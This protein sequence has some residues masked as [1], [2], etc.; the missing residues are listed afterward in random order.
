MKKTTLILSALL[1][2]ISAWAGNDCSTQMS[3]L[4]LKDLSKYTILT[5][6]NGNTCVS[7]VAFCEGSDFVVDIIYVA[8]DANPSSNNQDGSQA[9][10]LIV[11][12]F[13]QPV[14]E[15]FTRKARFTD[16]GWF[17]SG[18]ESGLAKRNVIWFYAYGPCSNPGD[19]TRST[20]TGS[21][22]FSL[23]KLPSGGTNSGGS[24]PYIKLCGHGKDFTTGKVSIWYSISSSPD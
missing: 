22:L 11:H 19:F 1:T 10:Y 2:T 8:G 18:S 20:G 14:G 21:G 17:I 24:A 6:K 15:E 16:L 12:E 23:A 4:H 3:V 9:E 7:T 13:S 5:D